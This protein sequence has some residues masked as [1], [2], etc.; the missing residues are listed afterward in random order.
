MSHSTDF[1][2]DGGWVAPLGPDRIEVVNPATEQVAG[3]VAQGTAADVDLAVAAARRAFE[4][5]GRTTPDER[6]TFLRA[7]IDGYTARLDEVAATISAEMGAPITFARQAQAASLIGQFERAIETLQK[8]E[9]ATPLSGTV[10]IRREPIGVAGLITAWNWPL[11]LIAG[12]LAYALAAGCTVVL[13]PSEVAPLSAMLLAEVID[14][15]GLPAGVFN[16]VNGDGATVGQRISAHPDV[17]M[18]SFTGSTRA[19]ILIA[20]AAADSVKR[21]HQELGG[22][23]ANI[24]LPDADHEQAVAAGVRRAFKNSGQ[25]CQAPTRMLVHR[26]RYDEALRYARQTAE[27]IRYGDPADP[28][29]EM[30]PVVSGAQFERVQSMIR[31]G[32]DQGA[33]VV[34]G[35]LGRPSDVGTGWFVRPTIFGDVD[36]SMTIA[37]EEIFGP[38]LPIIAYDTEDEA[39]AI[40]NDT[41][42]GLANYVQ[43]A[44]REHALALAPRLRSGRVYINTMD[45]T[46]TAPFGGYKQSGNG[47][48]EGEFGLEE[49]LETKAV[50][51]G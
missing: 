40:A 22:K 25:S 19:G 1:Y 18:V 21:V 30:G 2:I 16:L 5:W 20:K 35:G 49:Y 43:S 17:D 50:I 27:S 51:T 38:V 6:I 9:L 10:T 26:S 46:E 36:N 39:V 32:I 29:T 15:A 4:T 31:S 23:S 37:R 7:V 14:E 12:K 3:V 24:I 11:N 48:E 34:T 13:K 44:D 42:Y 8:Y 28:V 33:R 45:A 41:P 47:R